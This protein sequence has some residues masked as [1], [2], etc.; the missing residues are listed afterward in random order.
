[1]GFWALAIPSLIGAGA[2]L[3]GAKKSSDASKEAA[4]IQDKSTQDG[5][6][7]TRRQ[8]DIT[9]K[10]LKPFLNRGN[11]A[12]S[13]LFNLL[14]GKETFDRN[15]VPGYSEALDAGIDTVQK[16]A[17]ARGKGLSGRTLAALN[18]YGRRFD[19]SAFNTRLNQLA[20]V[21]GT[22]QTAGN[23]LGIIGGNTASS[24]SNLLTQGGNARASGVIGSNNAWQS[25]FENIGKSL[26]SLGGYLFNNNNGPEFKV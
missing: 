4:R 7:E 26:S 5:I 22:G 18:D 14:T 16:S 21:A 2:S 3:L 19:Q 25:G 11:E 20:G 15:S 13:K 8:F 1:M 10:N 23:T 17:F 12:G 6:K 9:Q 24:V